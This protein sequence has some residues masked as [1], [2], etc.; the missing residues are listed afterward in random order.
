MPV[1]VLCKSKILI[2]MNRDSSVVISAFVSEINE[3]VTLLSC[4]PAEPLFTLIITVM[5]W[6]SWGF[7]RAGGYVKENSMYHQHTFQYIPFNAL[8]CQA[9]RCTTQLPKWFIGNEG[10]CQWGLLHIGSIKPWA[11][12]WFNSHM[13]IAT[14]GGERESPLDCGH[15]VLLFFPSR[16]YLQS[17]HLNLGLKEHNQAG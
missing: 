16:F 10:R 8:Q 3:R 17:L 6:K 12:E 5:V 11:E 7:Q 9:G 13:A 4:Q 1:H 15:S 2:D 14:V